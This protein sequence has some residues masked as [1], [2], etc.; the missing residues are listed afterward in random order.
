MLSANQISVFFNRQYLINGLTFD[1]Y[2][3]HVDR[4]GRLEQGLLICFLKEFSFRADVS[5][6]T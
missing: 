4:Y 6:W 1:S 3:L 2:F 5:F